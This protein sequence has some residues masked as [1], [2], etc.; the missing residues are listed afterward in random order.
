MTAKPLLLIVEDDGAF[1]RTL[2]RSFER[3]NYDVIVASGP[4]ALDTLLLTRTP[5]FAVVDLKLAQS[6]GLS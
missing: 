3:R 1:A 5:D 6:S 2:Q 4:S